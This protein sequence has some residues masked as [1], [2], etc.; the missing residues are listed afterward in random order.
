[1]S[2]HEVV[3]GLPREKR[4]LLCELLVDIILDTKKNELPNDLV[5]S[6][7]AMWNENQLISLNNTMNLIQTSFEIDPVATRVLL[8]KMGFTNFSD[9]VEIESVMDR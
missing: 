6:I 3:S 8:T 5:F 1:M 2:V 7:L 4:A 9:I